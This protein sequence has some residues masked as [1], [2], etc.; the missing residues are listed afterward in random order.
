MTKVKFLQPVFYL[1][2]RLRM[3]NRKSRIQNN[4][5][6]LC[7]IHSKSYKSYKQ[8]I[9]ITSMASLLFFPPQANYVSPTSLFGCSL[10]M[11]VRLLL[12][13]LLHL[14]FLSPKCFYKKI[15]SWLHLISFRSLHQCY[16]CS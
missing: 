3:L 11:L 12:H 1:R 2:V 13:C 7:L 4:Q 16:L 5:M 9:S 8:W 6:T 14:L 15:S 10:R